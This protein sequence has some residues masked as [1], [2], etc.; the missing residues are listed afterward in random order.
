MMQDLTRTV[1]TLTLNGLR[2]RS[3]HADDQVLRR[4]LEHVLLGANLAA[5][6]D[7]TASELEENGWR[8]RM[9]EPESIAVTLQVIDAM[10]KLGITYIVGGSLASALYGVPRATLDADLIVDMKPEQANA[11]EQALREDFHVDVEEIRRA[12]QTGTSFNL[13]HLK[14]MFRVDVFITRNEPFDRAEMQRRIHQVIAVDPDRKAYVSTA[15]DTVLA[16]LRWYQS[17]GGVSERQW[18]D[19]IGI[20]RT[21]GGELDK[22]Y[23]REWAES[24]GILD[25]L[26]RALDEGQ[27]S[28]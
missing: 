16:K 21:Q 27:P 2:S 19:V 20:I 15:E 22:A 17:G 5:R 23:L 11:L 9:T 8:A 26:E 12:I 6:I 10:E 1:W 14:S 24:L 4:K 13:I 3:P 7:A 25:L 28:R 18:Q